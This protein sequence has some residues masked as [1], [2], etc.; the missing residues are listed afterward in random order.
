[1]KTYK[2][3]I[4]LILFPICCSKLQPRR[5]NSCAEKINQTLH[6]TLN[7]DLRSGTS[8]LTAGIRCVSCSSPVRWRVYLCG[9]SFPGKNKIHFSLKKWNKL[10]LVLER[11]AARAA[12]ACFA[13]GLF[14]LTQRCQVHIRLH[15]KCVIGSFFSRF[16]KN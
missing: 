3:K 5:S 6:V 13:S 10:L 8:A 11:A 2:Y 9:L 7:S 14:Q 1:M 12:A 16:Y 4:F 15:R